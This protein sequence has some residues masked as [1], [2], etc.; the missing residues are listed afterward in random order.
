MTVI[1]DYI[2]FLAS[3]L[4]ALILYKKNINK[5][6]FLNVWILFFFANSGA[7]LF[8]GVVHEFLSAE[9]SFMEQFFWKVTLLFIGMITVCVWIISSI[10]I[11]SKLWKWIWFTSILFSI[12]AIIIIFFE[13]AYIVAILFYFPSVLFL[14]LIS[15]VQYWKTHASAF[16]WIIFGIL[17]SIIAAIVQHEKFDLISY[18]LNYNSSYHLL[19]FIGLYCGFK[20][21]L[22]ITSK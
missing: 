10:I 19:Q 20:G 2:I 5:T 21:A 14:L 15:I 16:L 3:A 9:N 22:K 17:I 8:G 12:Y 1:T 18:Y 7:S 13:Q 11:N 4:F 6:L